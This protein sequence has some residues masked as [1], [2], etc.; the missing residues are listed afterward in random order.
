MSNAIQQVYNQYDSDANRFLDKAEF[1]AL[2]LQNGAHTQEEIDATFKYYDHNGDGKISFAEF[3]QHVYTAAPQAETVVVR[4]SHASYSNAPVYTQAAPVYRTSTYVT[5]A[6]PAQ[7]IN[8]NLKELFDQYDANRDG[9]LDVNELRNFYTGSGVHLS[10]QEVGL[11]LKYIN[12]AA[13]D[14]VSWNEFQ[15]FVRVRR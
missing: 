8:Y 2:M 11:Q 10:D 9:F 5:N 15:S 12:P 6:A 1:T 13:G 4:Q 3:K 7:A 14:R